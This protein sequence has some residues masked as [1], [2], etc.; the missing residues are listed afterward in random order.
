M[1]PKSKMKNKNDF[2]INKKHNKMSELF[3][4]V[5]I[6]FASDFDSEPEEFTPPKTPPPE[7]KP[8]YPTAGITLPKDFSLKKLKNECIA[9]SGIQEELDKEFFENPEPGLK[10]MNERKEHKR[11]LKKEVFKNY[12]EKLKS[13]EEKYEAFKAHQREY[14]KQ[15]YQKLKAE[16]KLESMNEARRK[17][18]NEKKGDEA[19]EKK[20]S[21]ARKKYLEKAGKVKCEC[22]TEYVNI[23]NKKERHINSDKHQMYLLKNTPGFSVEKFMPEPVR[24]FLSKGGGRRTQE[25]LEKFSEYNHGIK[26]IVYCS[27]CEMCVNFTKT[28]LTKHYHSINHLKKCLAKSKSASE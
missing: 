15:R 4:E 10:L 14:Q 17:R 23:P 25:D 3:P 28:G 11:N 21:E 1:S 9:E 5:E 19:F 24:E 12:R 16:N 27:I 18:Y 13:D 6:E 2:L 26:G 22:G 7:E 8:K 20:R